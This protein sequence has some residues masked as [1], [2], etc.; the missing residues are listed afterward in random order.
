M[1]NKERM[2]K[3]CPAFYEV[4]RPNMVATAGGWE[5]LTIDGKQVLCCRPQYGG[6]AKRTMN[7]FCYYCRAKT[8]GKKIGNKASWT[9][10]TPKWCPLG[11][12]VTDHEK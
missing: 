12:E 4:Q 6:A 10:K 3:D 5:Y 11:R 7:Q 1:A 2:C 9:G 8:L